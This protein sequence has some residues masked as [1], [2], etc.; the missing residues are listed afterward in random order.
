[1][2]MLVKDLKLS[3]TSPP[4][5]RYTQMGLWSEVMRVN[6]GAYRSFDK[7]INDG[8][9]TSEMQT[10]QVNCLSFAKLI[11]G[12]LKLHS[13]HT[14]FQQQGRSS[15]VSYCD[16]STSNSFVFAWLCVV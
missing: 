16:R 2:D 11:L 4:P 3:P 12:G 15:I 9:D 6:Q 7:F 13:L 10:D 1:M 14:K 5:Q 8:R